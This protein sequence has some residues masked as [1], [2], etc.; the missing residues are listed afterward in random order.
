MSKFD[1]GTAV[2]RM[3]YD[4]TAYGG[5]SGVIPEPSTGQVNQFFKTIRKIV[6]EA[7][8]SLKVDDPSEM[9]NEETAAA[10][11]SMS[12]EIV[13]QF[14]DQMVQ[15]ISDLAQGT[16]SADDI[17]RLPYR[18]LGAFTSWIAG[19]LRPEGQRPATKS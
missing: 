14:S 6:N 10:I 2:D 15:A 13:E 8:A 1:A 18:V 16:P 7:N 17:R 12:D 11:A 19:E 4:F 5:G 3:E 9:S